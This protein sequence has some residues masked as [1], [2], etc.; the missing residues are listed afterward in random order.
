MPGRAG[1]RFRE[2]GMTVEVYSGERVRNVGVTG[3]GNTGKT[4]LTTALLY[5]AG[6]VER[7]TG[8][9]VT[10]F[11]EEEIEREITIWSGLAHAEW[12]IPAQKDTVKVNLIDTPG[13][14]LFINDTRA[15]LVAADSSLLLVDAVSGVEVV[16]EKVWDYAV[17]YELPRVFVVSRMDRENANFDQVVSG[18]QERFGRAAVPVALPIGQGKDFK[19]LVDLIGM[20]AWTYK[21]D[22]DGKGVVDGL[23]EELGDTAKAAHEALVEMVAEG[24]DALMEEFFEKGTLPEEDLRKGLID[25]LH[26]HRLHAILPVSGL[27]NIGTDYLLNFIVDYMPDPTERKEMTGFS[28]P[29]RK[30]EEVKRKVANGEPVSLFVWKTMADSFAGRIS[31]FKVMSGTLKNDT[32]LANF[33]SGSQER[34]VNIS[35]AQGKSTTAVTELQA[36]DL[37]VVA[38]LKET[39]T[40]HTLG[41][42]SAAIHY[43]PVQLPEAL[44]SFAIEPKSRSDEEK[45]SPALHK[46]LEEDPSL[47]YGRDD[48]TGDFLLGGAGQAQIEVIVSKLKRRYGVEVTLKAPRIPY[49]ET[50]RGRADVEGKHKKQSGGRGQF[51]VVR[52]KMEPRAHGEGYE[53]VND[54]FGGSIPKNWIPSVD[55]GIQAVAA[56]GFLAGFPV[57]DFRVTLYDGKYHDVDSSDTAF[58]IAGSLAFKKAMET[59]KPA[60][61]E[62]IM[63][64]EVYSPSDFSGDLM[65]DVSGR[66]GKIQG[67]DSQGTTTVIKAEIPMAEMLEFANALTA[68]T[69]GRGSYHMEFSHY[70]FLSK[71]L[72]QK[73]I[74]QSKR[75]GTE[76]DSEG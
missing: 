39:V 18:V 50:I 31:Y 67:M 70:D 73:I 51:G 2:G 58:Q 21:P 57:V 1:E 43:P 16:T 29:D 63:K 47:H 45:M 42:K 49:R 41:D 38:K 56:K 22:G 61:I 54:I 7:L 25:A 11:D 24:D 48:Q 40:G 9:P 26:Q 64:V 32:H 76:S 33:S 20:K 74:A 65:G 35:V 23:P 12:K 6:A 10:D 28:E 60:I 5:T 19:G 8:S 14:N 55:K 3:H 52:I 34:L 13:Y 59:A 75:P 27:H 71:D 44:I 69:Q 53:F 46:L 72:E 36:G 15:S 62:P 17:E 30:G 4:Q 37:G 66:R 68:L